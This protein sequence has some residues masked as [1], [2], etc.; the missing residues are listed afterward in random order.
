MSDR[1]LRVGL[2]GFGAIGRHHARNL[3]TLPGATLVGV[4]DAS[5]TTRAQA[6]AAGYATFESFEEL[7]RAGVDAVV[8]A[9]PTAFHY[10][11]AM[12]CIEMGAA[13]LIEKPIAM[14]SAQG[15]EIVAAAAARSIPLM[16][17][18][19]ERY[20]PA[21]VA[22]RRFIRERTL[23]KIL[24][25]SARR[26]G[27]MPARI[28]DANVIVDI[29]VHDIDLAAFL[30]DTDL[31]LRSALGGRAKLQDRVDFAFLAL[32]GGDVPVHIET[33]WITPV[34]IREVFV[35]GEH[36]L[37]HVDL[38]TQLARFASAREFPT[39]TTF[40]GTIEQYKKGE[41]VDLRV[42]K[43]EPLRLEQRAFVDGIASGRLPDPALSLVSLRIAEQATQLIDTRSDTTTGAHR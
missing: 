42:E 16:V 23:G 14:T 26:V 39:V 28:Q 22:L 3:A 19:V 21:V 27:V 17:G 7:A 4:A 43:E 10:Q 15:A 9:V 5:E 25:I 34:K 18:Y 38:V 24:G 40:E 32:Q 31:E 8:L 41:F 37:C 35:T 29:G 6:A 12:R 30:L 20:N 1:S 11:L 36:G 33:N 13:V 2:I